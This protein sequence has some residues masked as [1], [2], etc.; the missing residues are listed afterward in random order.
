MAVVL[1]A[2]QGW[3]GHW[4]LP[5]QPNEIESFKPVNWAALVPVSPTQG[6]KADKQSAY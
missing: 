2:V 5:I 6:Q 1:M 3:E 4:L